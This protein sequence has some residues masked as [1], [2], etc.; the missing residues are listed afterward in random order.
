MVLLAVSFALNGWLVPG[1]PP[2]LAYKSGS[3][4]RIA[5]DG[6]KIK[7]MRWTTT[8]HISTT[9]EIQNHHVQVGVRGKLRIE[10]GSGVRQPPDLPS[11]DTED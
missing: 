11:V 10:L 9:F 5:A 3:R 8:Q 1:L 7:E 2:D 4:P 6:S